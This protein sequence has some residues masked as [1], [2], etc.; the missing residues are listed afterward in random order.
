MGLIQPSAA[1][2]SPH[3]EPTEHGGINHHLIQFMSAISSYVLLDLKKQ[4]K[5]LKAVFS[6]YYIFREIL[7][8][9]IKF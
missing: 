8:E 3:T 6:S 5:T 7:C 2:Q 4:K 9:K 1:A